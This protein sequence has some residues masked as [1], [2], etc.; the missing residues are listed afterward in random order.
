MDQ[1]MKGTKN[2][3]RRAWGHLVDRREHGV[4]AD[5]ALEQLVDAA[6]G[7]GLGPRPGGKGLLNWINA[8]LSEYP[9]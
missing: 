4:G 7:D 3:E 8:L 1:S 6:V 5:G 9:R 2:K